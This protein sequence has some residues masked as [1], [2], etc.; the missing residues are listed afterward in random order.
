MVEMIE[1]DFEWMYP[2]VLWYENNI[3]IVTYST[4]NL[5]YI[6]C[7]SDMFHVCCMSYFPLNIPTA[8]LERDKSP[9]AL[10]TTHWLCMKLSSAH[11]LHLP[12]PGSVY[13]IQEHGFAFK[14]GKIYVFCAG[15]QFAN[16]LYSYVRSHKYSTTNI[17]FSVWSPDLQTHE[18]MSI[19]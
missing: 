9:N 14:I 4:W 3:W 1:S 17:P 18:Q 6:H 16:K 11:T 5:W 8:I 7:P 15:S 10:F 12:L 13:F 19:R 2:Y